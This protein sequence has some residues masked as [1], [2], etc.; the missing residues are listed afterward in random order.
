MAVRT[1][2]FG[3]GWYSVAL[4]SGEFACLMPGSHIQSHLGPIL[5]PPDGQNVLFLDATAVD[6]FKIAGQSQGGLGNVE[7][8]AR[9]ARW[10]V[11]SAA[12]HGVN[13]CL[14]DNAGILHHATPAQGSQGYRF[15]DDQNRLWTGDETY[16]DPA[17]HLWEW[18]QLG[19]V[20]IGFSDAALVAL[21]HGQRR[22]IA[23]GAS[24]GANSVR[25]KR[26]GD[27]C[28][29]AYHDA[30]S[31]ETTLLWFDVSEL[32]S[33][34]LEHETPPPEP[35]PGPGPITMKLPDHVYATLQQVRAKYP[36][37]LVDKGAQL[38]NEVAWIHRAEGFGLEQKDGGNTCGCPGIS[39]RMGCD[40]LRTRDRGWDVLSDAEGAGE[41]QQADSG[42]A[43]P[44]RFVA[45]VNP[46]G[47][48]DPPPPPPPPP[49]G[50]LEARVL[51]LEKRLTALEKAEYVLA[52]VRT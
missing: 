15:C 21:Y 44:A 18:T 40:I 47:Q 6:G 8:D 31:R 3:G 45:P 41:P 7:F 5:F 48:P 16:H 27:A 51:E 10:S 1:L 19:D 9:W 39:V 4:P 42:P 36:T 37:P 22:V 20:T 17:R 38:L 34:P 49:S 13:P 33:L 2:T 35:V 25:F 43:D 12:S 28:A 46:S 29:L 11:A 50:A 52:V 30:A 26:Q 23:R 14:Y 32:A 24:F